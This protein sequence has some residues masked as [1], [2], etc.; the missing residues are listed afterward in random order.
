MPLNWIDVTPI[1]FDALLLFE[2]VQLSWLPGWHFPHPELEWTLAAHPHIVWTMR[3]KC[4]EIAPWLDAGLARAAELSAARPPLTPDELRQAEIQ[5]LDTLQDLL[6]YVLDP[7]AYDAQPF[8]RWDSRDLTGLAD[9]RGKIVLDIGSGTGRL[10]FVAAPWAFAVYPVEPVANLR[11]YLREQARQR[12]FTNVYPVDGLITRIPFHD[13][14]ADIVLSG[15]TYGDDPQAEINELFR[16][17]KPDGRII[18]CPGNNDLDN[19]E[20]QALVE[21]GFLWSRFE[22]P[23]PGGGPVRKYWWQGQGG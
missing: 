7:A 4:P 2:R 22:E 16:V 9:F 6:V 13:H 8:T 18:L 1:P 14:F 21:R 10:A 3:H 15:H 11:D 20:H 12:G 5:V 19:P 23:G 17:V